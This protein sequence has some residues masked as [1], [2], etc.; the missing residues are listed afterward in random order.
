MCAVE[1]DAEAAAATAAAM[2]GETVQDAIFSSVCRGEGG[3]VGD[4]EWIRAELDPF[5][6][7]GLQSGSVRD[8]IYGIPGFLI[9][10]FFYN[11]NLNSLWACFTKYMD[12][13]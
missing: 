2:A 8:R 7:F 1:G 10:Y 13:L 9:Y 5:V 3:R 11:E 12:I 4:K 6:I